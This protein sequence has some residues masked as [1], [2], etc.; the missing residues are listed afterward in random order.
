MNIYIPFICII[1]F[2]FAF[3]QPRNVIRQ[4][5]NRHELSRFSQ[6]HSSAFSKLRFKILERHDF[7][8]F[9]F[10]ADF[11]LNISQENIL[12][13]YKLMQSAMSLGQI[14]QHRVCESIF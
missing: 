5:K 4:G 9:E 1:N 12:L 7:G 2:E 14:S 3:F 10:C 8:Q 6:R 11:K 13:K